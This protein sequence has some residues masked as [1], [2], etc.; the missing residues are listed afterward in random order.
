MIR[1]PHPESA[2]G[3]DRT[4]E[5]AALA[6]RLRRA[7]PPATDPAAAARL[8]LARLQHRRKGRLLRAW[9]P[10]AGVAAAAALMA[11]MIL[12]PDPS[13]VSP[14]A[15]TPAPAGP[16]AIV[17]GP[18]AAQI[19]AVVLGPAGEGWRIDAG[20]KD[21]LRVG[22]V[23]VG[24]AETEA[25]VAAVGIFE[26]RVRAAKPLS[27]G[28]R[29]R[30]EASS[31]AQQRAVRMAELGGDPGAFLD[32]GAV[33]DV[34]APHLARSAGLS[35][36]R[37][38]IVTETIP[39]LLR[40]PGDAEPSLC[41]RLGLQTGDVLYEVNGLPVGNLAEVARALDLSRDGR[42]LTAKVVRAGKTVSLTL[43]PRN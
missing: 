41:A 23:L 20:L 16:A 36:S 38:V 33:L 35:D 30:C 10:A 2:D 40:G 19:T 3:F 29:L 39:A 11:A 15:A 4:A 9:A 12:L 18:A 32:F 26:S 43:P 42:L 8:V 17:R 6:E 14:P 21:G 22:D 31:P 13:R 27:R 37:A 1:E 24:P 5:G 7:S 25:R 28:A 34:A